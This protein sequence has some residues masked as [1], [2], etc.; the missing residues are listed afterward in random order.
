VTSPVPP[1]SSP[2]AGRAR[3]EQAIEL[4]PDTCAR[5]A[6]TIESEVHKVIVGQDELVRAVVISLMCEGH[7][8]LEGVPGLGKTQLLKTLAQVTGL[9]F[10]R[11]QFTP[12]LMPADILGT[13]ILVE[14]DGIRRFDFRAGPVFACLVLA[15]EVNRGTPK[16]QS[17]LLEAMGER[18]ATVGGRTWALPRP[19][20]V[21]ATQNPIEMEGTYPL[22]EAQLDRFFFKLNVPFPAPD[23][24]EG[25]LERTTETS[26]VALQRVADARLLNAMIALTRTVVVPRHVRRHA[27]DLVVASHAEGAAAPVEVKRYVRYGASPRGAQAIILAAKAAALLDGRP[28]VSVADVR[29]VASAALRHRLVLGYEAVAEGIDADQIVAAVLANV[30]EPNPER[31][32]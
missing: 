23:E 28:N 25:I 3:Q 8:L 29:S 22:P 26:T 16:T 4:D 5:L 14:D 31:A 30:D 15:D 12:D 18:T 32:R 7:V 27:V 11:I 24:L 10:A 19:F 20:L 21:M 2:A 1:P 17:A 9:P 13:Y 6:R